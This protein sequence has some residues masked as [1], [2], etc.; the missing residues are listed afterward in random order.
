[1]LD[2]S[3]TL[4]LLPPMFPHVPWD[5]ES[6]YQNDSESSINSITQEEQ[7]EKIS[8]ILQDF[9]DLNVDDC[10]LLLEESNFDVEKAK[11]KA[12]AN[13]AAKSLIQENISFNNSEGRIKQSPPSPKRHKKVKRI[14]PYYQNLL[15]KNENKNREQLS[16]SNQKNEDQTDQNNNDKQ[17]INETEEFQESKLLSTE[18]QT[19]KSQSNLMEHQTFNSSQKVN[20]SSNFITLNSF[21]TKKKTDYYDEDDEMDDDYINEMNFYRNMNKKPSSKSSIKKTN[22]M[23][24][25]YYKPQ[26]LDVKTLDF[27][28]MST[29]EVHERV[30][31]E[32][33]YAK[34]SNIGTFHFITGAGHHSQDNGPRLKP[35]VL[36]LCQKCGYK[37]TLTHDGGCIICKIR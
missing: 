29:D 17:T 14:S 23:P 37:P 3:E 10:L 4:K 20:K 26:E 25:R 27:H 9:P 12:F 16:I 8:S 34:N 30:M 36:N 13:L 22:R 24:Q 15:L 2:N 1:M 11:R 31:I 18:N 19:T 33:R 32:L 28:G 21:R 5:E 35:L 6:E 7:D